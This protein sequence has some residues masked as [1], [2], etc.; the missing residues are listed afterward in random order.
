MGSVKAFVCVYLF[1]FL[2]VCFRVCVCVAS[3]SM[4]ILSGYDKLVLGGFESP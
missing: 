2:R 3:G 4:W 1:M